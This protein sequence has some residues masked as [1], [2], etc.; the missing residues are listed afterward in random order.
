[1][2]IHRRMTQGTRGQTGQLW[3]ERIW[4]AI[5]TCAQQGRSVFEFS[6]R[7]SRLTSKVNPHPAYSPTLLDAS[8]AP[9]SVSRLPF[10]RN[11]RQALA[12]AGRLSKPERRDFRERIRIPQAAAASLRYQASLGKPRA[13]FAALSYTPNKLTTQQPVSVNSRNHGQ[14]IWAA[15]PESHP[16][17]SN[18]GGHFYKVPKSHYTGR[19]GTSPRIKP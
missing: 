8:T 7:Q 1:M 14:R 19:N 15:A 17:Q 16:P 10:V 2:A 6:S 11:M 18:V 12:P 9:L 4:T 5:A 13:A 3:S